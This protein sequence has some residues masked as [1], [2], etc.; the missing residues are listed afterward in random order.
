MRLRVTSESG[1]MPSVSGN[2]AQSVPVFPEVAGSKYSSGSDDAGDEVSRGD[3]ET[4]VEGFTGWVRNAKV[5]GFLPFAFCFSIFRR[6]PG[7]EDF[8]LVAFFDGDVEPGF[9]V[10]VDRGERDRDVKWDTVAVGHDGFGVSA[11]LVGDFTGAAERPVAADDDEV[12]FSALHEMTGG[13][14]RDD[15]VGDSLLGKLPGRQ[16]GAL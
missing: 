16:R 8:A 5:S 3:V 13:V 1:A 6:T 12:D 9:E 2:K 4:G 14:V 10:P 15:L 7:A 11:D